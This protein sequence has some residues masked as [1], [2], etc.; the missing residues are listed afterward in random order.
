MIRMLDVQTA[1]FESVFLCYILF[2]CNT[3]VILFF[4]KYVV[5]AIIYCNH[6]YTCD[7]IRLLG[8]SLDDILTLQV[9]I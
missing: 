5:K 9:R 1:N 2:D 6:Y 7:C 4:I 3:F 8:A